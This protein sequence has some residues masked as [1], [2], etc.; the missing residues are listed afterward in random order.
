MW[1]PGLAALIVLFRFQVVHAQ[2]NPECFQGKVSIQR[3]ENAPKALQAVLEDPVARLCEQDLTAEL[4]VKNTVSYASTDFAFT[5]ERGEGHKDDKECIQAFRRIMELCVVGQNASGGTITANG[6]EPTYSVSTQPVGNLE[7]RAK[8]PK[9]PAKAPVE[10]PAKASAKPPINTTAKTS[11]KSIATPTQK[12]SSKVQSSAAKTSSIAKPTS[13]KT[14]KKLYG[15]LLALSKQA[16]IAEKREET[17]NSRQGFSSSRAHVEKRS[18]PKSGKACNFN[19]KALNYPEKREMVSHVRVWDLEY[20]KKPFPTVHADLFQPKNANWYGF[21]KPD[22]CDDLVFR[23][24]AKPAA[25]IPE[26][27]YQVEHVLEWN[28]VTRFFDWVRD[29]KPGK[30]F[31][32][33]DKAQKGKKVDFCEYWRQTWTTAD[34][35]LQ[36]FKITDGSPNS[37]GPAKGVLAHL[38][39]AF[40]GKDNFPEEFVYLH[41]LL[42]APAKSDVGHATFPEVRYTSC[43]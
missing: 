20:D 10:A 24:A 26:T 21:V 12:A 23:A 41:T 31:E 13:T 33:P 28:V 9:S 42:N 15:E 38:A 14:C 4:I 43:C 40:P 27:D 29:Q 34:V 1:T 22:V 5:I 30:V 17:L 37:D 25:G 16:T 7:A 3:L 32:H 18:T 39:S 8:K 35:Q 19:L 6:N 36:T 2:G 11:A